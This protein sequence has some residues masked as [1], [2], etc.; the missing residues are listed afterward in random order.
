MM[1]FGHVNYIFGPP[2]S[3]K[4]TFMAML[5]QK[6][7]KRGRKVYSNF[8]VIGAIEID[9]KDIGYY[10]FVGS[11][12]LLDECGVSLSNRDFK[13]GLMSDKNRLRYWKLVRHYKAQIFLCSQ[14]WNDVD[15]KCRD[16]ATN[17]YMLQ[18]WF[19]WTIIKP[20]Y[21]SCSIDPMSHEPADFFEF[22]M[23]IHWRFCF[24]PRYYKYFDSYDAPA[25]PDYPDPKDPPKP[26]KLGS[27]LAASAKQDPTLD[28]DDK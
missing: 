12:I 23:F 11:V 8:P 24:R 21:K 16:L 13:N 3:G 10:N 17:Y 15:K 19:C 5:V 14:G 6:F 20:V 2:G 28:V 22:D 25:L 27:C 1:D 9:D 26:V 7:R 18:K 4:S